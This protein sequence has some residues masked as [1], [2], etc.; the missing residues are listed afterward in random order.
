MVKDTGTVSI[1]LYL[2]FYRS[3][4]IQIIR[5]QN[6]LLSKPVNIKAYNMPRTLSSYAMMGGAK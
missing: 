3:L 5:T 6:V 2:L 1:K 4:I